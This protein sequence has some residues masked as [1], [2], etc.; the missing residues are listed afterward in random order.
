[1]SDYEHDWPE[2][3]EPIPDDLSTL[4]LDPSCVRWNT[5]AETNL[6]ALEAAGEQQG[7]GGLP[8]GFVALDDMLQGLRPGQF[9]VVGGLTGAG[10]SVLLGDLFRTWMTLK[11]PSS[12]VTLEMTRDEVWLRQASA[13]CSIDH[14]RLKGGQLDDSDW[15]KLARW[16]GDT[17]DAPSWVCDKPRMTLAEVDA[18]VMTG[19]EQ[20][21]WQSVIVDYAQ[22]VRHKAGTREREVAEIAVGLKEIGRKAK[23]PMVV[24]AQLNREA[25]KR[26]GGVPKLSDM[27]ESAAL[28]H[29]ADIAIL[30]H[31]PDYDDPKSERKGEADFIVEKNRGGPKGTVTVAA[32]MHFQRFREFDVE[33]LTACV[34][35]YAPHPG[36]AGT[37]CGQCSRRR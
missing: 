18:L 15:T 27:R 12:L 34:S 17:D 2:L 21:G 7:L 28:E 31:R 16:V 20:H 6:A 33:E 1:M 9:V 30:V 4:G 22:I 23:I 26:T 25:N 13:A 19:V 14:K 35:C 29:E 10:K 3:D 32:Q 36:Q 8:T 24:G 37:K 11:I 5:L